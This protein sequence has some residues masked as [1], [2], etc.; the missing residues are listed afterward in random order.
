VVRGTADDTPPAMAA[1]VP[2]RRAEPPVPP[3]AEDETRA[4]P[5][6]RDT[7]PRPTQR[8]RP[9]SRPARRGA[10]AIALAAVAAVLFLAGAA[11]GAVLL[12][13][14]TI[15]IVPAS[16]PLGPRSYEV[17]F[18]DAEGLAGTVEAE[19]TVTA[20]GTYSE[21][22]AATGSVALYNWTFF[23]VAV[24]AGTFVAAGEQ[25][26]AT[27]AD[28]VVPRGRL[29]G[30]GTILA[31]DVEVAVEAAAVGPAANVE[32]HAI[33][34]VVNQD[35]DQR[36]RGFPENPERRVDNPAATSGGLDETGP[37]I[38]QADVDAAVATLREELADRVEA[39]LPDDAATLLVRPDPAEPVIEGAADLVG[40][41]D[42]PEARVAGTLAWVVY[43]VNRDEVTARAEA[44]LL[45]DP[46]AIPEGHELLPDATVV[47]L[48]EARLDG[49]GVVVEAQVS[50]R[51][52]QA[53][54]VATIRER[55]KGRPAAEAVAALADL[56][57]ATVDLWPA[58]VA[59]VPE[60]DWRIEVRISGA[61]PAEPLPSGSAS[62]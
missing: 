46:S 5:V 32:A 22:V 15:E 13:A 25:A 27:Q 7:P 50:G 36:L 11:G 58:W 53:L 2:Q 28:V 59:S 35:V 51:S 4:V 42:Q 54:D 40:A 23:P 24:P 55:V 57:V 47:T 33:D 12:P 44:E 10:G 8:R 26:F 16:E 45:E 1:V 17:A 48:G 14:A 43:S 39:E 38:T 31:G 49:E 30:A 52:A 20:T 6:V 21:Q 60:L 3:S 29:T 18:D 62:P 56:G 19:A 41:R 61:E 34:S 37:E 9:T